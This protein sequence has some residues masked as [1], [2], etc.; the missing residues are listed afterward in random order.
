M[1]KI[2]EI[3]VYGKQEY[4]YSTYVMIL[5]LRPGEARRLSLINTAYAQAEFVSN[6]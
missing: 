1:M 2:I 6:Q 4:I 5:L 3:F